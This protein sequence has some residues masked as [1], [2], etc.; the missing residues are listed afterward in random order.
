MRELLEAIVGAILAALRPRASLAENLALR[1]QLAVLRRQASRPQLRPVDR[2]FWVVLSRVWSRWA[3]ALALVKPATVIGWHR[4]GFAR[5]WAYKSRRPGRPPIGREVVAR[6]SGWQ[7]R[8]RCGAGVVS[9]PN[10]PSSATTSART[11][12]PGTC[13]WDHD[14]QGDRPRR[15]GA[16]SF[17]DEAARDT[18]GPTR[19]AE[20]PHRPGCQA[21]HPCRK[22]RA[23]EAG[24]RVIRVD[25]TAIIKACS[26]E[27]PERS[28]D[29]GGE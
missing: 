28:C 26:G 18:R 23:R 9:P 5:F 13:R 7:R 3:D 20:R 11:P 6:S 19:V 4:R 8:T 2:E 10:S 22:L 14:A 17:G 27:N 24:H 15:R 12:S 1:R 25:P 21:G 16:H 29:G